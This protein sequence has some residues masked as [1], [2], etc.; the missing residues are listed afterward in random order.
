VSCCSIE[1]IG[2]M[3]RATAVLPP[4][5]LVAALT[6]FLYLVVSYLDPMKCPLVEVFILLMN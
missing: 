6:L 4:G 2:E 3:V 5:S 1:F